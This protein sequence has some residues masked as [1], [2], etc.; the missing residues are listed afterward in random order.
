[1]IPMLSMRCDD[2]S[3]GSDVVTR[4][5]G[6]RGRERNAPVGCHVGAHCLLTQ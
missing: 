1:M 4:G 6:V 2:L 5:S 3:S